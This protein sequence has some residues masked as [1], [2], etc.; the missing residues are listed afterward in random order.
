MTQIKSRSDKPQTS[1]IGSFKEFFNALSSCFMPNKK[2]ISHKDNFNLRYEEQKKSMP[3]IKASRSDNNQ[4][5]SCIGSFKEFFNALSS[6]FMPSQRTIARMN[7]L[8]L[9]YEDQKRKQSQ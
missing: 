2:N 9:R 5:T 7:N 8:N 6:C 3:Q 1:Y 4:Q